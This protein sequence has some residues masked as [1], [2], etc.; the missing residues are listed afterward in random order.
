M[1]E[2]DS[3]VFHD[4]GCS[5]WSHLFLFAFS[6]LFLFSLQMDDSFSLSLLCLQLLLNFLLIGLGFFSLLF[7]ISA[8][9][10]FL[11]HFSTLCCS[12]KATNPK[13]YN[14]PTLVSSTHCLQRK[15]QEGD[16]P[17]HYCLKAGPWQG[18]G[19]AE[20]NKMCGRCEEVKQYLRRA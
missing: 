20:V 9:I 3:R 16:I 18:R 14:S 2:Q 15:V 12:L 5:L 19:E 4:G 1:R 7:P 10:P 6:I 8:Q 11:L 17:K 13:S